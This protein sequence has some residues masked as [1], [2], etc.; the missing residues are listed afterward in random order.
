MYLLD[1]NVCVHLLNGR[2]SQIIENFKKHSPSK[3]VICSVVK[4]ELFFGAR[5]SKKVEANL[6]LLTQFFEPLNSV[7]FGDNAAAEYGA[8]RADLTSQGKIIGS[9]DLLIAAIA[10]ANNLVLVTNN[11][12]EFARVTGLRMVDWQSK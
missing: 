2:H 10:K 4:A 5:N 1:T 9:N 8:I 11:S 3:L 7:A 12:K 6:Q